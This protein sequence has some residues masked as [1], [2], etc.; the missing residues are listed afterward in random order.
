MRIYAPISSEDRTQLESGAR[1]LTLAPGRPVWG[2]GAAALAEQPGED[3]EDLEYEAIQDA[4][5]AALSAL[6]DDQ[7]ALVAAGDVPDG[8]LERAAETGGA[9]GLSVRSAS[10]M[11]LVSLHVTELDAA[12]ADADDTDPALL[13]FDA[14]EVAAALL[15]ADGG[16]AARI[17]AP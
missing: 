8:A 12:A 11:P 14:G 15:F 4:V 9:F 7:R 16:D 3:A 17:S 10:S 13:W 1:A 5:F 6:P 2:V